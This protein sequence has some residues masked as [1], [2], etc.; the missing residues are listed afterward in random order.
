MYI[1]GKGSKFEMT[2]LVETTTKYTVE[3]WF[4]A[5]VAEFAANPQER[6]FL[7]MMNGRADGM[8]D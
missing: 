2:I 7:Y 8:S 5:N 6:T 4:K 1:G 3:F